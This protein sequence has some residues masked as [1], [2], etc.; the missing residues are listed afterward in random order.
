M[1]SDELVVL[2]DQVARGLEVARLAGVV[3]RDLK[4][5]N[6]FHHDGSVWKILDFGVSKVLD[7]EGTL[8]GDGI[9]GTPQYMAPE[10][11]SGGQVTHLAD[12]YALGAIAYRCLTGR[13]PYAFLGPR[14]RDIPLRLTTPPQGPKTIRGDLPEDLDAV[15][16]KM[17][18]LK[19]DERPATTQAVIEALKGHPLFAHITLTRSERSPIAAM[20]TDLLDELPD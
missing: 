10:Q 8:T 11:A 14:I 19:P 5:H 1:P 18:A 13:S 4:P 17:L 7:S 15:V 20:V 6:L 2:L 3:H 9:V 16:L 12:V